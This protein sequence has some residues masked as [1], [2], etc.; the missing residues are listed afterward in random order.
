MG[1]AA[2]KIAEQYSWTEI[3]ERYLGIVDRSLRE[4]S[5][6]MALS[7]NFRTIRRIVE[8]GGIGLE[9]LVD[10]VAASGEQSIATTA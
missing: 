2:R 6:G 9:H 4:K 8:R 3:G 1:R 7:A 10:T 5:D